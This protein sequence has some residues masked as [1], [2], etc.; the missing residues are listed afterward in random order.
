MLFHQLYQRA[1][2][3]SS[4]DTALIFG[5]LILTYGELHGQVERAASG[6]QALG[7]KAGDRVAIY[8]AQ[9][10]EMVISMLAVSR[11]S[12]VFVPINPSLKAAQVGHILEDSKPVA[13]VVDRGRLAA[14]NDVARSF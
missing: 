6:L 13:L 11:S 10:L 4:E 9:G 2:Q 8:A 14:L 3:Q 5:D 12:A 7:V 1:A